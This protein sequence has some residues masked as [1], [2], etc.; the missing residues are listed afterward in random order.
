MK[1]IVKTL[2][3]ALVLFAGINHAAAQEVQ[4]NDNVT[5]SLMLSFDGQ[6]TGAAAQLTWVME[7]ETNSKWFVVERS[8]ETGGYDSIGVIMGINNNNSQTTYT[9]TDPH[10]LNGNNYYRLREV[11]MTGTSRYSKVIMLFSNQ[12][13][14]QMTI[15]PN[16][17]IET[18]NYNI[19]SAS[20]Q[21]VIV[22]VYS[23]AG[24]AVLT[25]QQQLYM[26]SNHQSIA[27]TG[28]RSG[29]YI[30]RVTNAE[31]TCQFVE[32]FAKIM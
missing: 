4:S 32:T 29:N 15:Y 21:Q 22:Q 23:L 25:S 18:L 9:Y 1:T 8:G 12:N 5:P 13:T 10:M 14:A 24:V 26:G 30:L 3:A 17:A 19:T 31:G 7:N 2:L 16:P 20:S 11:D 27:I 6:S 28:L